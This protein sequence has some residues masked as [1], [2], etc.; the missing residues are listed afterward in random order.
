MDDFFES[1]VLD[2]GSFDLDGSADKEEQ[3]ATYITS[4]GELTSSQA[5]SASIALAD[6]A[7]T[8][9]LMSKDTT[10]PALPQESQ[11][12]STYNSNIASRYD[13]DVFQ[14]IVIDT[15]QA[16]N[17]LPA[18]GNSRLCN[19]PWNWNWTPPRKDKLRYNSA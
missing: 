12:P 6:K 16:E 13:S 17:P 8:H 4:F 3:I 7:F 18:I 14:G 2:I 1:L 15:E 5:T 19:A 9:S 11:D 10:K